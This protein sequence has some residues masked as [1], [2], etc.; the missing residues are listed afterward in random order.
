MCEA[1]LTCKQT[2]VMRCEFACK[3]LYKYCL[4]SDYELGP[5]AHSAAACTS[6]ECVGAKPGLELACRLV[7]LISLSPEGEAGSCPADT[8][9]GVTQAVAKCS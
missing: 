3:H 7:A 1:L 5:A 2:T 6:Q 9:T 8:H 4:H